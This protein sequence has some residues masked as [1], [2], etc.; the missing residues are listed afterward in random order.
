MFAFPHL[1]SR[2]HLQFEEVT[3]NCISPPFQATLS[4]PGPRLSVIRNGWHD[5][6]TVRTLIVSFKYAVKQFL[7]YSSNST[8]LLEVGN[9]TGGDKHVISELLKA[10][11]KLTSAYKK[12][13]RKAVHR[14]GS[15]L[16]VILYFFISINLQETKQVTREW[17]LPLFQQLL[18]RFE[19]RQRWGGSEIGI[20]IIQTNT[21]RLF[22]LFLV[23]TNLSLVCT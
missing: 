12:K 1:C 16:G 13:Q 14:P 7:K 17:F 18:I 3:L 6:H 10:P 9:C 23:T 19:R 8:L 11:C 20:S 2:L 22:C 21:P 4:P 5:S 15:Y